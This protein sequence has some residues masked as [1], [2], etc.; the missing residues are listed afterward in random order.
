LQSG[1]HPDHAAVQDV[2]VVKRD[3]GDAG[4]VRVATGPVDTPEPRAHTG[5]KMDDGMCRCFHAATPVMVGSGAILFDSAVHHF[6]K[7]QLLLYVY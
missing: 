3:D 6:A 4:I 1:T 5:K 2:R 7:N